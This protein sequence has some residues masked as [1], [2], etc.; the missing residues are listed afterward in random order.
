[1]EGVRGY[2]YGAQRCARRGNDA[3][4]R[5]CFSVLFRE[6]AVKGEGRGEKTNL[7]G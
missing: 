7:S 6:V 4:S 1:M 3:V 2:G 5:A